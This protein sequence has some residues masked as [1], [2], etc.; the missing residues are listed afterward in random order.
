MAG[1]FYTVK[2]FNQMMKK[3]FLIALLCSSKAGFGQ[4]E[5]GPAEFS[6]KEKLSIAAGVVF[7]S[8]KFLDFKGQDTLL[9]IIEGQLYK[10]TALRKNFGASKD[11][12]KIEAEDTSTYRKP[13]A[14]YAT[15]KYNYTY[16]HTA[17]TESYEDYNAQYRM[18]TR[19]KTVYDL[20]GFVTYQEKRTSIENKLIETQS[21]T[22]TFDRQNRAIRIVEKTVRNAK[23]PSAETVILAV[24]AGNTVTVS[25]ENGTVVCKLISAGKLPEGVLDLSTK[26]TTAQ[27]MY[28]LQRKQFDLAQTHCTAQMAKTI[29]AYTA[30]PYEIEA[31]RFQKGSSTLTAGGVTINDI[32]NLKFA[33]QEAAD[34]KADFTLV[35]Q[36]DGWK[37]DTF[38]ISR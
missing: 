4:A 27:F 22:T 9:E 18:S 3:L 16:T 21:T 13:V 19:F 31:L 37:I 12:R 36:A 28:A 2:T 11:W 35:K 10:T 1:I 17:M 32:W 24:Y 15:T 34:Y 38:K 26:Q 30:L 29:Q 6:R 23:E 8:N 5:E 14:R 25:G 20:K 33:G 7:R